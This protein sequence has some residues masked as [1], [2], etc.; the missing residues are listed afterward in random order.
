M[1]FFLLFVFKLTF[2][3][4]IIAPVT[5]IDSQNLNLEYFLPKLEIIMKDNVGKDKLIIT[6]QDIDLE[7]S[8]Y[9]QAKIKVLCRR[10]EIK[11]LIINHAKSNIEIPKKVDIALGGF[12]LSFAAVFKYV[13]YYSKMDPFAVSFYILTMKELVYELFFSFYSQSY[14]NGIKKVQDKYGKP[15]VY[16]VNYIRKLIMSI[17]DRGLIMINTP[18]IFIEDPYLFS[19]NFLW[20]LLTS[21]VFN[22]IVGT[23]TDTAVILSVDK[24]IMQR[25]KARGLNLTF[26]L[27]GIPEKA[28]LI[29]G[30]YT[31]FWI[32]FIT[33][34]VIKSGFSAYAFL[35]PNKNIIVKIKEETPASDKCKNILEQLKIKLD[36]N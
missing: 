8:K 17:F 19:A 21:E 18:E 16:V 34:T 31:A 12:K 9:E 13:N 28:F 36:E 35:Y 26:D 3:Y 33:K 25:D 24:G 20:S 30:N 1:L 4:E 32:S 6:L 11:R 7:V 27:L 23:T 10:Y 14:L 2:C 29:S 15:A 22:T 5:T